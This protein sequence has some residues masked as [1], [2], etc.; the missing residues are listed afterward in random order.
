MPVRASNQNRNI[1]LGSQFPIADLLSETPAAD[2][3][4]AL[5]HRHPEHS[6]AAVEENPAFLLARAA[7]EIV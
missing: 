3:G 4:A 2:L 7:F 6:R 1:P 5:I